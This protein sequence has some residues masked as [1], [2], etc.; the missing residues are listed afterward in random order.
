MIKLLIYHIFNPILVSLAIKILSWEPPKG[1]PNPVRAE[2]TR[3][4]AVPETIQEVIPPIKVNDLKPS[5]DYK[6]L[7]KEQAEAGNPIKPVKHRKPIDKDITCPG[8]GAPYTFIYSNAT[9]A[10]PHKR[11][12]V[13]KEILSETQVQNL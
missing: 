4:L 9:V 10:L 11:G 8:C 12:R 5:I 7:L 3:K 2:V 6:Q 1:K 13:Q